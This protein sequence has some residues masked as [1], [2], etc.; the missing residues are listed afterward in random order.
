MILVFEHPVFGS[1]LFKVFFLSIRPPPELFPVLGL[2][3]KDTEHLFLNSNSEACIVNSQSCLAFY[4]LN[5]DIVFL[6]LN[7]RYTIPRVGFNPLSAEVQTSTECEF[8]AF[9]LQA[10]T[11]GLY[12]FGK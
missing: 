6:L 4:Y 11:A 9:T 2:Y 1:L 10:T 3:R 7:D 5:S 8:D 12:K